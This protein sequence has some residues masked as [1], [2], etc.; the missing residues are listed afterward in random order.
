MTRAAPIPFAPTDESDRLSADLRG[1]AKAAGFDGPTRLPTDEAQRREWQAANKGWWEAAPM[2]YDWREALPAEPGS[3]EYFAEIDRRF[4][5]ATRSFLPWRQI[6]FDTLI[7]FENLRDAAVLEIGVGHGTHAGLLAPRCR[8]FIGVDLTAAAAR[9]TAARLKLWRAGGNVLQMDAERMGF[10]DAS[11]DYVWSWG[12]VHQ[13]ADTQRLMAEV[14]RVLRPGGRCTVMVYHRSWWNYYVCG[15][16]RGLAAGRL[17]QSVA[18]VHRLAQSGTDGALA[19]YYRAREWRAAMQGLFTIDSM[20][21]SGLKSDV[22]PLPYGRL[23][24]RVLKAFP[25]ALARFLTGRLRMGS[26]LI[27]QMRKPVLAG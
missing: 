17:P 25:D 12:V 4:F 14:N 23:K 16:L 27:V 20:M 11:F 5:T 1:I 19:R 21:I 22:V 15:V 10:A 24:R 26:L 2:R 3:S 7:D 8:Q 13:T 18:G 9:M 6:P